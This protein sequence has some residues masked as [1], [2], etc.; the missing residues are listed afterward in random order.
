MWTIG[1]SKRA[2]LISEGHNEVAKVQCVSSKDKEV[3]YG[4][5]FSFSFFFS[6]FLYFSTLS[7]A[8]S[9][10]F[11]L[12]GGNL[13]SQRLRSYQCVCNFHKLGT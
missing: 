6:C 1:R 8:S 5:R 12:T 4:Q 3:L 7:Y 11:G 2:R 9:C 10:L 13:S